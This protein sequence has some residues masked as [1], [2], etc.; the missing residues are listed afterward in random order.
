MY[1]CETREYWMNKIKYLLCIG[2]LVFGFT[3][4]TNPVWASEITQTLD[5][6]DTEATTEEAST[7]SDA[8]SENTSIEETLY[9]SDGT[10]NA[11][12][13]LDPITGE[14]YENNGLSTIDVSNTCTY[15]FTDGL[16]HYHLP[17]KPDDLFTSAVG[18]DMYVQGV[19]SIDFLYDTGFVLYKNGKL[20]E[21][22]NSKEIMNAGDYEVKFKD[23][24]NEISLMHFILIGEKTNLESMD[25]PARCNIVSVIRGEDEISYNGTHVDFLQEGD[26]QITYAYPDTKQTGVLSFTTDYTPP[27][28]KLSAL[29]SKNVARGPVDIS[30]VEPDCTINIYH[31]EKWLDYRDTL[32]DFGKYQIIL[33]DS[34]GNRTDY[35]FTIGVYFNSASVAFFIAVIVIIFGLVMRANFAKKHIRVR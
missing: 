2:V 27:V 17:N 30:D 8:S 7:A 32:T 20:L 10:G 28:L 29:N 21:K 3:F 18:M 19:V 15:H 16:Y 12:L 14:P 24:K 13:I 35:D 25:F 11:G 6:E 5:V 26:Y 34:A 31:N 9:E 1:K 4:Y 23:G 22:Y 33:M